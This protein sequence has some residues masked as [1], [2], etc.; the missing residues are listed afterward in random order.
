MKS[1][2]NRPYAQQV[3]DCKH[4]P[5]YV[6]ARLAALLS[7]SS[8][9]EALHSHM[10]VLI[11]QATYEASQRVDRVQDTAAIHACRVWAAWRFSW[12]QRCPSDE[13]KTLWTLQPGWSAWPPR[14]PRGR[15]ID[16]QD[17]LWVVH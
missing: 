6:E 12:Q 14:P 10:V 16:A 5:C 1:M 17:V 11:V 7:S 13:C 15:C 2:L 8:L 4:M 9:I 3:G